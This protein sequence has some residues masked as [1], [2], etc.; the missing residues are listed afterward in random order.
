MESLAS[1]RSSSRRMNT[2]TVPPMG[3]GT[4]ACG[5]PQRTTT[6]RK[7]SGASVRVSGQ[8]ECHYVRSASAQVCEL[9]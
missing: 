8:S 7:R 9:T 4:D 2:G 5:A 3:E 6:T 1:S